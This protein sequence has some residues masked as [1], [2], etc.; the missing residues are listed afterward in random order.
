M[1]DNITIPREVPKDSAL[2]YEFLRAEGMQL[3]QKMAGDTWTDHNIHDPGITILEQVCYAITDLAY[4]MEFDI[5]DLLGSHRTNT[6][7]SLYSPATILTTNPVTLLDIRKMVIDVEGVKNAWVE[8]VI[9]KKTNE[10]GTITPKG[11]F[12]VFIEKDGLFDIPGSRIIA[13]VREKLYACR[14]ICEDFE[15]IKLLD[16]QGVRLQGVI[17]ISDTVDD[18]NELVANMLHRVGSHFSPRI[19]FYTLQQQLEKGKTTDEIFDGPRLYHGFIE[20]KD[21]VRAYRKEEIQT[22]D[23]IKEIMDQPG[24]LVIDKLALATGTNTIKNWL[25][26]LDTS[27]TPI[28][29]IDGTLSQ[30][31][32]TSKGLTVSVDTEQIKRIYN[33]KRTEEGSRTLILQ[34]KDI[35][36]PETQAANLEQYYPIQNQFPMNYGIGE[37]GLPESA[38]ATRKAQAKQLSGYLLFFEQVVANYLSQ[39]ANF[40][41][42]M[43]FDGENS[44]TYFNQDLLDCVPGMSDLIGNKESYT[45]YLKEMTADTS[46]GLLRKNK[47]LN[48]LLARFGEKFT[49]YGM[50]LKDTTDDQNTSDK[51]LIKDKARFLKEYP[52]VS[53]CKAKGYDIKND[54]WNTE[55][56]S[57]LE[58]RIALKIG[59]ED[60]SRRNLGDGDTSGFHM[61][62]HIL[63]RSRKSYPYPFISSYSSASITKFEIAITK[64][65]TRCIVG[66]H[67]LLPGEE[68]EIT[69]NIDYNGIY[70]VLAVGDDFFEIK[71][72]FQESESGATWK[73]THDMRYY[74]R[75]AAVQRFIES[76]NSNHTFC[77]IGVHSLQVGDAIEITRTTNYNGV[78]KVISINNDGFEI[79]VPFVEDEEVGRWMTTDIVQDPY[80][81]QLTFMLPTWVEQYQDSDFKKFIALTIREETPVHIRTNIQWLDQEEMQEFDHAYQR[82]L[83]EIQNG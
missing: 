7:D 68:V 49:S 55:N 53:G 67:N 2:S 36:L 1:T 18:V 42:I 64:E 52:V 13:A 16:T 3:I 26:P 83:T 51:K 37:I 9:P 50:V 65:F 72:P 57:G 27:K 38:S 58:K 77:Q 80:S 29:D 30:L 75:S 15:E 19:P 69:N 82:F 4:R 48:H 40:K 43:S 66:N 6:Y 76:T 56:I 8:K 32:F 63:L 24:I 62:E 31:S 61:I 25:L 71:A 34:E 41:N 46:T 35:V 54:L 44:S 70:T 33:Q 60:Y 17:E 81:L 23:V 78:H 12:R 22:S 14:S 20:D 21:L 59:I 47:F 11:L 79:E 73:R 28:L 10:F 74:L 39:L 5:Q 45:S